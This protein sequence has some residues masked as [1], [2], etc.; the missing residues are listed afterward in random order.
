MIALKKQ[1]KWS[2]PGVQHATRQRRKQIDSIIAHTG[3]SSLFIFAYVLTAGVWGSA[4]DAGLSHDARAKMRR[5][6]AASNSHR[7]REK[8]GAAAGRRR[9]EIFERQWECMRSIR[10][11][12]EEIANR[13]P[14]RR[15][16]CTSLPLITQTSAPEHLHH[17]K[18]HQLKR[19]IFKSAGRSLWGRSTAKIRRNR[20]AGARIQEPRAPASWHIGASIS[21][22]AALMDPQPLA[23]AV[24]P[25]Q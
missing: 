5:A 13:T 17:C 14:C 15:R 18:Q 10:K 2:I 4:L 23:H 22:I 11:L 19:D 3:H 1:C 8:S 20:A 16:Q 21:V 12:H 24:S 6:H 25:Y 7:A 9:R